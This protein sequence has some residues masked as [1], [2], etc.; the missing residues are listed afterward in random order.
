MYGVG[1]YKLPPD[2]AGL[3]RA[4]WDMIVDQAGYSTLDAGIVRMYI[5]GHMAQ[6]DAAAELDITER[7]IRRHTESIIN[8]A[9]CV[10]EKLNIA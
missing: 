10:A 8:R 6:A 7:T 1:R 3:T 4:E 5:L 9:R 2:L